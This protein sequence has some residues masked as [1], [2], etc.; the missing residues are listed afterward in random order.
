MSAVSDGGKGSPMVKFGKLKN[1]KKAQPRKSVQS[2]T[3]G[4]D[5][6]SMG[7]AG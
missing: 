3:S 1:R 5:G 2:C 6:Y 4:P 7:T